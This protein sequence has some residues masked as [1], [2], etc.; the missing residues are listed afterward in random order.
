MAELLYS[1]ERKFQVWAY[2][3]SHRQLLLRSVKS[4]TD[5]T[6]INL[7]FK[8]VRALNLISTLQGIRIEASDQAS[9]KTRYEIESLNFSGFVLASA[10]AHRTDDQEYGA[11]SP[12]AGF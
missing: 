10:F 8:N 12:F 3:V 6:R 7:L 9:D 2:T 4:A 5:Q 1:S 11:P